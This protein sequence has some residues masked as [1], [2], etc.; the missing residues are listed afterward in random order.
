MARYVLLF[1]AVH[2]ATA[3]ALGYVVSLR[4]AA[5][6]SVGG[7]L[8]MIPIF[9]AASAVGW[10]FVRAKRR[11]FTR[12]EVML[13]GGLSYAYLMLFEG[14]TLWSRWDSLPPLTGAWWTGV[15]VF[16]VGLDA[17]C[18]WLAFR[19]PVRKTMDKYLQRQSTRVV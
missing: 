2:F 12:H 19:Y 3:L 4:V 7:G 6:G 9:C 18:L 8:G 15:G 14:F 17:L 13:V 5:G 10:L 11:H 1:V 16:T